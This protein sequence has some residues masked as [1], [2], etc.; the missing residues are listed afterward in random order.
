MI[1]RSF[2]IALIALGAGLDSYFYI[3][4]FIADGTA[5]PVAIMAAIALELLLAFAVWN[6]QN[7]KIFTGVAIA[8]TLYAVIQTSA[9]QTFS[10]ISRDANAGDN[11]ATV[12]ELI[13]EE[14]RTLERIDGEYAIITKQLSSIDTVE[15]RAD[16]SGT[17]YNMTRRLSELS[18]ARIASAG[19]IAELSD[20]DSKS[21]K[22]RVLKMSIYDFY[23]SMPG[24][25]GMD[26]LKF[27]FHTFFSILIAIMTP[28]GLLTW[29]P[30]TASRILKKSS[31]TEREIKIWVERCWHKVRIG[32][33]EKIIT[34]KDFLAWIER[35]GIIISPG[36]YMTCAKRALALGIIKPDLTALVKNEDL[37][38]EKIAGGKK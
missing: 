19:K 23:A 7:S 38:R 34:E 16:Y 28:V 12:R 3:F 17:I 32:T 31:L 11:S 6:A 26:W 8:I 24:W 30:R 21:E 1:R 10:L 2:C 29:E 20:R 37:I 18:K 25:S 22:T 15:K 4:R 35:D 14:K 5:L 27:C 33:N 13:A 36:V 9:G